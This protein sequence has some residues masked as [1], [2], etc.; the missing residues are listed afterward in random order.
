MKLC[1]FKNVER[2]LINIDMVNGF[3]YTGAMHDERIARII[4]PQLELMKK[5]NRDE[6]MVVFVREGHRENATEFDKFPKHCVK[7][8]YEAEIV[9]GLKEVAK[10]SKIYEKNSTS[11]IFAKDFLNDITKM[12]NLKEVILMGCCTDIC[13]MNLAIPLMN[14][15]DELNRN[16]KVIV[17]KN[18]VETYDA[19][20][21]NANDYNDMAFAFMEQAGIQ[22]IDEYER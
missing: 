15:F 3:V 19:P 22:V 18:V 11:A 14:Y 6:D 8:T 20:T 16:V 10:D 1:K 21:H 12:I 7:G 5:C 2:L 13:V 17:P 9:D 4:E